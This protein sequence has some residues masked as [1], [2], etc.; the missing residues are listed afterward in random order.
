MSVTWAFRHSGCWGDISVKLG[1]RLHSP[2]I[3]IAAA[4]GSYLS[5]DTDE[6]T[7]DIGRKPI[8]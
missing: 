4:I 6:R 2:L 3:A 5:S 7:A 8:K 1:W